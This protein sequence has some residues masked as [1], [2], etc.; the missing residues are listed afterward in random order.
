MES[1]SRAQAEANGRGQELLREDFLPTPEEPTIEQER[2]VPGQLNAILRAV[3]AAGLR[4]E[5]FT[6]GGDS[7]LTITI[8]QRRDA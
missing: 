3:V 1:K 2:I 8:G 4:V 6:V 7:P 5:K